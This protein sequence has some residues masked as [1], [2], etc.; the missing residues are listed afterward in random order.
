MSNRWTP[1]GFA[2]LV[3]AGAV[4]LV[5]FG[6]H[7]HESGS[8]HREGVEAFEAARAAADA[9]AVLPPLESTSPDTSDWSAPRIAEYRSLGNDD[10][11]AR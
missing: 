11:R 8:G 6:R 7:A 1:A 10:A 3:A 5:L 9:A 4:M 2:L